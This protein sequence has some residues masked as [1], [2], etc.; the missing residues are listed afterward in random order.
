MIAPSYEYELE[1]A[2]R[3][4]GQMLGGPIFATGE[5]E[6]GPGQRKA[7]EDMIRYLSRTLG[8]S[9]AKALQMIADAGKLQTVDGT[10]KSVRSGGKNVRPEPDLA[11]N[12]RVGGVVRRVNIEID[13]DPNAAIA[14]MKQLTK[15]DPNARHVAV[16]VDPVTGKPRGGVVWDPA[17]RTARQLSDAEVKKWKATGKPPASVAPRPI[18]NQKN[19]AVPPRKRK[20]DA[21]VNKTMSTWV[22]SVNPPKR[23][24]RAAPR[25]AAR[26]PQRRAAPRKRQREMEF[27]AHELGEALGFVPE[28]MDVD[29]PGIPGN[30]Q[31]F[32]SA[33]QARR[34]ALR[35][36]TRAGA[37][38]RIAHDPR[39][40]RGQPHYHVVGPDGARVSGHYFYGKRMPRRVLR[41][42][43]NRE[44][45][46][47][48]AARELEFEFAM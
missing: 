12:A 28:R 25:R 41:G 1:M 17:T 27:A 42:R 14:H 19:T 24:G 22:N 20:S 35:D 34:A 23:V 37:G 21:S 7:K 29:I 30:N 2:G 44:G 38:Y 39:P 3:A 33:G 9:R 46:F 8:V 5:R 31:W 45:E 6:D 10:Q 13:S 36:A 43:P 48:T 11:Y 32:R 26:P 4:L 15:A 16:I 40:S 18:K 47:D